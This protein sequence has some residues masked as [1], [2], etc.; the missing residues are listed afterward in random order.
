[1]NVPFR[2][3]ERLT[4]SIVEA[5]KILGIGRN[6]AYEAARRGQIPTLTI[7][8]RLLVPKWELERYLLKAGDYQEDED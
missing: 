1:M 3:V 6:S 5:A 7:G 8:R 2:D 4:L